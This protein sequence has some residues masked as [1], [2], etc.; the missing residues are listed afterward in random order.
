MSKIEGIT[1]IMDAE[2]QLLLDLGISE[3]NCKKHRVLIVSSPFQKCLE[4]A[5][6]VW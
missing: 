1:T 6:L 4:T 3:K 5:V 2:K